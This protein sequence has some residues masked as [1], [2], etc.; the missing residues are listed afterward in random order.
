MT[1]G[2][3]T[4]GLPSD[5][6]SM[7]NLYLDGNPD[8]PIAYLSPATFTRNA[9]TTDSGQPRFY[10]VLSEEM[11][12]A[13]IADSNYTLWMLYYAAPTFLS[14]STSTNAFMTYCPDLLLYGS[15]TEAEPY[16]MNDA[17]IQTW[18]SLFQKSLQDLTTSDE[19]AEYAGNPMVMTIQKR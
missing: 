2:D 14:D 17:R 3:P 15:L 10:T 13:P 18:A 4:V 11:Q 6:L 5:F 8:F 1:G 7:R 19:E 16:L 9:P 12:F